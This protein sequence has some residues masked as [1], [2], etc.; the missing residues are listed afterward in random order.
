MRHFSMGRFKMIHRFFPIKDAA[1]HA[2]TGQILNSRNA[3]GIAAWSEQYVGGKTERFEVVPAISLA[4]FP[5]TFENSA[6]E[7]LRGCPAQ[8]CLSSV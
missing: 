7:C 2:G 3:G 6:G 8:G 1:C 4:Q 5:G